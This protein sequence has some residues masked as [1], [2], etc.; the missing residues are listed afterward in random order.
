MRNPWKFSLG[1]ILGTLLSFFVT[2]LIWGAHQT[3]VPHAD[4]LWDYLGSGVQYWTGWSPD[5]SQ[6]IT[7][8]SLNILM[9]V[10]LAFA[11][12]LLII[13]IVCGASSAATCKE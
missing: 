10:P 3:T 13:M 6:A 1:Y 12:L 9:T 11:F 7:H 4:H 2:T 5:K 8:L